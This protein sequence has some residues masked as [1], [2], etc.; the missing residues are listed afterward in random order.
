MDDLKFILVD[1]CW[2]RHFHDFSLCLALA[3]LPE[4]G[5]EAVAADI[6]RSGQHLVDGIDTPAPAV[7]G[8][9]AGCVEVCGDGLDAHRPRASIPFP[10]QAEDQAHCLGLDGIDLQGFLGPVSALLGSF[11]DPVADRRQGAIP[12]ALTGILL[13]GA[14]RM[15]GVLLG[16]VLVKQRHDL[17]DHVAHRIVAELLGDRHQP[18]T[19]L[20][21]SANV[22]LELELIA[23]EAAEA[24]D[25]DHIER[26]RLRGC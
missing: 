1:D 17:S 19:G 25:Q 5:I 14:Q 15:L 3:G 8:S 9:D 24:V 23:E 22:E 20:G 16:L 10:G 6:G 13:H 4:L 12:E 21:E 18:D 7:A 26:R 2:H 11:H